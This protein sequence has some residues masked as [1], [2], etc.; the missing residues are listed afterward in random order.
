LYTR[1]DPDTEQASTSPDE[2]RPDGD[3]AAG[4]TAALKEMYRRNRLFMQTGVSNVSQYNAR[5]PTTALPFIVVV[6]DEAHNL[7]K[8][9]MEKLHEL[10]SQSLSA[11]IVVLISTQHPANVI[12]TQI[13]GNYS[14]YVAFKVEQGRNYVEAALG[15]AQGGD[16]LY[17]PS[18]IPDSLPG[19]A[20]LRFDDQEYVGRAPEITDELQRSLTHQLVT[21]Y[22]RIIPEP[23]PQNQQLQPA[24]PPLVPSVTSATPVGTTPPVDLTQMTAAE[25]IQAIED[26]SSAMGLAVHA[27]LRSIGAIPNIAPRATNEP[28]VDESLR[29]YD[30]VQQLSLEACA[31]DTRVKRAVLRAYN[32]LKAQLG[33]KLS[34]RQI[35]ARVFERV[36][37]SNDGNTAWRWKK[38]VLPI[39]Q[40][41]KLEL[42]T[43]DE[44]E[45][46]GRDPVSETGAA[47]DRS[48]VQLAA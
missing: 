20:V 14:T 13:R 26:P 36:P 40:E 42:P 18:A 4:F 11:G 2:V 1:L 25:L 16:S 22:P 32:E 46:A 15:L 43:M 47:G 39:L 34:G 33:P 12:S 44:D 7:A 5:F 48:S 21:R 6:V 31:Q 24:H 29:P 30:L 19:T 28:E 3:L 8:D 37:G 45:P 35:T 27:W 17:D 23:V 9:L 41:Y 10:V 38:V